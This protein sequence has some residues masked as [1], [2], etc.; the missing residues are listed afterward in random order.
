MTIKTKTKTKTTETPEPLVDPAELA[1]M[2]QRIAELEA[3]NTALQERATPVHAPQA[4]DTT[5]KNKTVDLVQTTRSGNVRTTVDPSLEFVV[6][7]TAATPTDK[8]DKS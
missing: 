5:P 2:A 4:M 7:A 1:R 3:K 8:E 6:E